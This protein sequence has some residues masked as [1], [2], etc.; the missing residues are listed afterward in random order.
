MGAGG[1]FGY[2][3]LRRR[4]EF[5]SLTGVA[6]DAF[7][8]MVRRLRPAWER[9]V[10][11][12]KTKDGRPWGVGGLGD[13]L[14]VLLILY[15]C[16]HLTQD[17]LG[18]L[19][20]VNKSA[21]SRSKGRIERIA[22]K[23]LGV[24]RRILVSAEEAQALIVDCTEQP[25]QRPRRKQRGYYAGKRKRHTLKAEFV[26][27][28]H[29]GR[30]RIAAVPPPAPGRTHDLALRRRGPPVPEGC[31]VHADSAYQGYEKEHP[32][33]EIP[34][35]R[36]PGGRLAKDEREYNR[37]RSSFRVRIE[38]VFA[39]LQSF[40]ILRDVVRYPRPTYY[41][42]IRVVAGILN[43]QAGFEPR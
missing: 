29:E 19:Y 41:A 7:D 40:R 13:H 39:R 34:Y 11:E 8:A 37:A 25:V 23:V 14:S 21:I 43:L 15:R 2:Q 36:P 32:A 9:E 12:A 42:T 10:V 26:A 22:A 5:A 35:R 38:H 28:H 3:R 24:R 20:G 33:T 6:A 27:T 17:V 1:R 30:T 16:H 31:R 4:R 18:C